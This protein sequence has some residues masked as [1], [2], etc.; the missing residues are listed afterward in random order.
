MDAFETWLKYKHRT[1]CLKRMANIDASQLNLTIGILSNWIHRRWHEF[2]FIRETNH[3]KVSMKNH[4]PTLN[5][6]LIYQMFSKLILFFSGIFVSEHC[7]GINIFLWKVFQW[8]LTYL[9]QLHV[10]VC[11]L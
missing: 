1:T 6:C 4:S 9:Y 8:V 10:P 7:F 5:T 11:I 2:M 3:S